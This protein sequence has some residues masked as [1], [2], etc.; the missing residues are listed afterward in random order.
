MIN[1]RISHIH[2]YCCDNPGKNASLAT[3]FRAMLL[4]PECNTINYYQGKIYPPDMAGRLWA[5]TAQETVAAAPRQLEKSIETEPDERASGRS[6]IKTETM[7]RSF[8]KSEMSKAE[9]SI[10]WGCAGDFW[11]I[12]G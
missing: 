3:N 2:L 4:R 1:H 5:T 8:S 11:T 12:S 10:F 6:S 7:E 9:I